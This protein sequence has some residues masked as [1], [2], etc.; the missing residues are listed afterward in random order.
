MSKPVA[1]FINPDNDAVIPE[2]AR[3][4]EAIGFIGSSLMLKDATAIRL[5]FENEFTAKLDGSDLE[6]KHNKTGYYVE[7]PNIAS[8]DLDTK[9]TFEITIN[10]VKYDFTYCALSWCNDTMRVEDYESDWN[11]CKALYLYNDAANDF[12]EK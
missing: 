6:V 12:F 2:N 8:K 9:Y 5:Y 10:G 1:D 11:I 3:E 4:D 7:K